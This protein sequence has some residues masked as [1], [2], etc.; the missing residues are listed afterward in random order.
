MCPPAC[1]S[2][3]LH[4]DTL[5]G[6]NS[7]MDWLAWRTRRQVEAVSSLLDPRFEARLGYKMLALPR[8]RGV[9]PQSLPHYFVASS[10]LVETLTTNTSATLLQPLQLRRDASA[11][12]AAAAAAAGVVAVG[13]EAGSDDAGA[14]RQVV[15]I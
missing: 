12:A 10:A 13:P 15:D 9:D 6:G 3:Y 14:A 2:V 8:W 7:Q 11:H 1:S 5:A 4:Q